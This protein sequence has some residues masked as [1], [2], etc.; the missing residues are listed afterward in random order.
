[1]KKVFLI[2]TAMAAMIA[3]AC[4]PENQKKN[5]PAGGVDVG[6]DALVAY[7]PFD[8]DAVC[9]KTA[10]T[11]KTATVDFV[12]G[13]RNKCLQGK[14]GAYV[15]WELPAD[16]PLK[17]MNA[18]TVSMWLKQA[19]IPSEEV[20]VPLFLEIGRAE[21][22]F[23]GNFAISIDRIGTKDEPSDLLAIKTATRIP[24]ESAYGNLWK[25]DGEGKYGIT[26]NRWNH[27][28]FIYDNS[29]SEYHVY[30]NGADATPEDAVKCN[31]AAGNPLG[32]LAI[33]DSDILVVG[34]WLPK[35]L[36]GDSS[37]WMGWFKGQM[38][39][40]RIFDRALSATE[41]KALYTAEVSAMT[42]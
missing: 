37:D 27:L 31:N 19:P 28:I 9:K 21:D 35:I 13:R 24:W 23:W 5:D 10:L 30:L 11:P 8:G 6:T 17:S 34:G 18:L 41:A 36:D 3:V 22:H 33:S 20:P 29:A 15:L 7:F 39:E 40:L 25:T 16:S 14:D 1:M 4:N 38:D 12:A 2:I 32:N 42:E 26:G